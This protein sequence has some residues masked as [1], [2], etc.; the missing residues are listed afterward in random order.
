M[1]MKTLLLRVAAVL[2]LAFIAGAV[3]WWMR[4][5]VVSFSDD[6][7]VTLLK[8]EYGK[9]HVGPKVKTTTANRSSRVTRGATFYTTNDTLVLWMRQQYPVGQN[10]YHYFSYFIYDK[11]GT[12]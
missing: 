8:V 12:A 9:H 2:I 11:A 10:Q 4:P 5:Q 1:K 3:W 6:A 7:K